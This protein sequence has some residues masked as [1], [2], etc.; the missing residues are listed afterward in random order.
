MWTVTYLHAIHTHVLGIYN[1]ILFIYFFT[2]LKIYVFLK[3]EEG[4]EK[5]TET[6]VCGCLSRAPT[7]D[8]AP[9]PGMCPDWES[10]WQ[11]FGLQAGYQ[12]TEPHQPG[13][14][15]LLCALSIDCP[16]LNLKVFLYWIFYFHHS[17]SNMSR[18]H[19][20][21]PHCSVLLKMKSR[22]KQF[23]TDCVH[24]SCFRA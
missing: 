1:L 23:T 11:P 13:Q 8:L 7:G 9:N 21:L 12:S 10:N 4:R 3:R 15:S 6:A 14:F 17:Y 2:F 5:E 24:H 22:N 19:L 20:E 18:W 16:V